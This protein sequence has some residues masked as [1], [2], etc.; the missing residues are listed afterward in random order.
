[1]KKL[2]VFLTIFVVLILIILA[3]KYSNIYMVFFIPLLLFLT[4]QYIAVYFPAKAR[5]TI[6]CLTD[7]IY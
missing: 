3:V 4:L 2:I 1:M 5:D 7:Y 6:F